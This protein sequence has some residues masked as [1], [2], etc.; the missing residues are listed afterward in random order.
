MRM[1]Y[2]KPSVV[3]PFPANVLLV[4]VTRRTRCVIDETLHRTVPARTLQAQFVGK[5]GD[6]RACFAIYDYGPGDEV[7]IKNI[8]VISPVE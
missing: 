3:W 2:Y 7:V 1:R 8:A 5:N 4:D 6:G